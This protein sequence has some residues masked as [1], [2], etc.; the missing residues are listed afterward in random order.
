MNIFRPF[1]FC[2][3]SML[4]LSTMY[5]SGHKSHRHHGD[6][7][8][9]TWTPLNNQPNFLNTGYPGGPLPGGAGFTVLLTDGTILVQNAGYLITS[10]M[11][12]FTPDIYGSYTNGTWSQVASLPNDYVPYANA[13]VV[14]PDGRV[15]VQGGEYNG[16]NL[17]FALTNVGYIYDPVADE[18]ASLPPPPFFQDMYPPRRLFA[19]RDIGDSS[20]ICLADGSY[21]VYSKMSGQMAKLDPKTLTWTEIG[22]S[23]YPELFDEQNLN[24]LPNGKVL[25][26]QCYAGALFMPNLYP[27]PENLTGSLIFDPET[28]KW[29]SAGSTIYPMSDTITG[30]MGAAIL[31]PD[32]LVAQFSGNGTG[33]NAIYDYIENT[34][35]PLPP[36]PVVNGVQQTNAD[37]NAT[38]LPNGNILVATTGY[39]DVP[40]LN[41]FEF[42]YDTMEFVQQP[43]IPNSDIDSECYLLTLPSGQVMLTDFSNDVEIYTPGNP[44]YKKEWAPVIKDSPEKVKPGQTYKIEGIRFNGMS[45]CGQTGDDFA[46]ATN[47]PLVRITNLDTRHVFYC[48]THDHSSMAVASNE[49]VY[50]FF[51][52]PFNIEKGESKIEV[53]ANGISSKPVSI[54]VK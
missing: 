5:G 44:C 19:P 30:E 17:H 24:L 13:T 12:K 54:V 36:L 7:P 34:W 2:V 6:H 47:Y 28:N 31:R 21:V 42:T 39:L 38:L 3:C 10:Q 16:P 8:Q 32:G 45:Q 37:V 48:R 27:T 43:T 4:A 33:Q 22:T 1:I 9:G 20:G 46:E 29:S 49:K 26:V 18:W 40:P 11:W 53:V 52:V 14:L 51:D 50:T 35:E 25:T 23:S 15:I 41:F